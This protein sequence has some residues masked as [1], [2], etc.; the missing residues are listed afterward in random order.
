MEKG[1]A[2]HYGIFAWRIP[3]TEEAGELE[4]KGLQKLDM[5]E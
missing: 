4:S 5:I 2:T 1:K 3:W